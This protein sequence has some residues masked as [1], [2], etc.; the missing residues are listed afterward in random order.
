MATVKGNEA[1]EAKG[2]A[3]RLTKEVEELRSHL[4]QAEAKVN[5]LIS[6][7]L[8]APSAVSSSS[9]NNNNNA[10]V[11]SSSGSSSGKWYDKPGYGKLISPYEWKRPLPPLIEAWRNGKIDW[12]DLIPKHSSLWE[13]YGESQ[14]EKFNFMKLVMKEV[15]VTDYLT[16]YQV[17]Y[18][19]SPSFYLFFKTWGR[20]GVIYMCVRF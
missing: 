9:S 14:D 5:D 19:P 4:Q 12:H 18:I 20:W 1:R 11:S 8:V 16:Q 15:A 3:E 6:S 17:L 10:V 13:R 7:A 2:E